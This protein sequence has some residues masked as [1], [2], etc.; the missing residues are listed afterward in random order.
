VQD[1][2]NPKFKI[3]N[4]KFTN[5]SYAYLLVSHG[6]RDPR[7]Q[8]AVSELAQQLNLR[9]GAVAPVTSPIL[10]GTAQLELA[11]Q[12]LHLQI[13]DF[14]CRCEE[15]GITRI[16]ILPL[17]L[18]PGVHAIEDIPAE[19]ALAQENLG[20]LVKLIVAPFLGSHS[21]FAKL[22]A[23]NRAG[24]PNQSIIMAHGSRKAGGNEIVEELASN[25]DLEPA[26]WSIDPSLAEGVTALV[27]IGATEIGI[28]PYFLFA[29][30]ITDS[31]AKLVSELR[32]QH[33]QVQLRLG[34]PI[35][36]SPELVSTID[37]ILSEYT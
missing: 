35:G 25:L 32:A 28:L 3:Q 34:E 17:F 2:S 6:S 8:A 37:R 13:G 31:I 1:V 19:V 20:N 14:A 10:V 23:Q 27:A 4:S 21:E 7:P 24:L 29:G 26:Y 33:P 22:F 18:I 30:G 16:V 11:A 36:N 9:L 12:P 15:V 5:L